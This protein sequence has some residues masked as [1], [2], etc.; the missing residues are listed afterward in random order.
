[1]MRARIAFDEISSPQVG[2]TV[3][4]SASTWASV[5]PLSSASADTT[6][7]SRCSRSAAV[8]SK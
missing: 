2:P 3:F 6:S 1:M 5:V 8:P 7:C 4:W